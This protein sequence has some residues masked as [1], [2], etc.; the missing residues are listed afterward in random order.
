M[1]VSKVNLRDGRSSAVKEKG[2]L[3]RKCG[4]ELQR[5]I[6]NSHIRLKFAALGTALVSEKG[7]LNTVMDTYSFITGVLVH[8][9]CSQSP[10]RLR[11]GTF[12]AISK[13]VQWSNPIGV[14]ESS[15]I[16]NSGEHRRSI[17][18]VLRHI[19]WSHTFI[20]VMEISCITSLFDSS[21]RTTFSYDILVW[22]SRF[23]S[24]ISN[25]C[26]KMCNYTAASMD[27]GCWPHYQT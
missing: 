8:C 5:Q 9:G 21:R 4:A 12:R 24:S 3:Q 13:I 17:S 14:S 2:L 11:H 20:C 19:T 6:P 16:S 22:K 7:T 18:K 23:E 10:G 27:N 15:V 25:Y 1:E 26:A